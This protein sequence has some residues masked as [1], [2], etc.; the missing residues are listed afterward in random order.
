M[1]NRTIVEASGIA[2]AF[3][4]FSLASSTS[5]WAADCPVS[6]EQLANALRA[7]VKAS[8][9][10]SNG[11]FDSHQW[12][13]VVTRDGTVCAVA[14]SGT[15]P[16]DQWPGSRVVSIGKANTANAF[17]T[18][19]M[20]LSTANLFAPAQP[21]QSLYGIVQAGP[22]SPEANLGDST[23]FGTAS[24][25]ALGKRIGGTVVFGGGLAL[26]NESGVIGGIGVSGDTSCADHNVAWRVRTALGLD[27]TPQKDA[28]I[29]DLGPDGKSA[30]GFGHVKCPGHEADIAHEL[31]A[32]V[33]GYSLSGL[34][35]A[36]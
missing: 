30:S 36:K 19:Q 13:S 14:F 4:A 21:G 11:G 26:Y 27:K 10:P 33:G 32:G 28:I 2:V 29:Y 16:D 15:K 5:S 23:Q 17:S 8:G 7:S 3:V 12:A 31:G 22:P 25:P 6:Y 18:K 24:D 20:A 9:G 34:T 1:R 35:P